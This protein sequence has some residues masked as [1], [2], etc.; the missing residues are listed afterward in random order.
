M[1]LIIIGL[2]I[3]SGTAHIFSLN[4]SLFLIISVVYILGMFILFYWFRNK[5]F[6]RNPERTPPSDNNIIVSPADGRLM[7]IAKVING[8]VIST[9]NNEEIL[10]NE[11]TKLE[12][13]EILNGW[14]YGIYMSPFDVHYNYSPVKGKVKS[15][16]HYKTELNLPMV[17]L[18]EYIN[19]TLLR[20]AV[21]LF[22]RKFHFVNE[23]MT[24]EF[25]SS[26]FTCYVV[27]IADK[28]VNKIKC[29]VNVDDNI[30]LGDK[31]SFIARGSQVDLFIPYD[32]LQN[33]V[34]VGQQVYGCKS[35]LAMYEEK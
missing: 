33:R 5:F 35:I 15:I 30:N 4:I 16:Y 34:N 31:I 21:N 1:I 27:L 28:F 26:K 25:E 10:I 29:F 9:K 20:R 8:K 14:L 3:I 11:I 12:E 23:R 19:F 6:S 32:K 2:L 18:W 22:S 13:C 17:D 24:L 7:Y